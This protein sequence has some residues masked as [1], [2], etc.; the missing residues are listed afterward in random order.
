MLR[1]GIDAGCSL[2]A[3]QRHQPHPGQDERPAYEKASRKHFAQQHNARRAVRKASP[4]EA[5]DLPSGRL[6]RVTRLM[7]LA[8][9]FDHLLETGVIADQTE[10]AELGYVT[11]ARVTQIMNLLHLAPDIQEAILNLPRVDQGR[12][13]I[14][15]RHIRH[16]AAQAEWGR[17]RQLWQGI[18]ARIKT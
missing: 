8:I 18:T 14:A 4:V 5:V 7:A 6:P 15:E 2:L 17:Q 3:G 13:P 11:R 10:I 1:G 16:I 9:H 12:A